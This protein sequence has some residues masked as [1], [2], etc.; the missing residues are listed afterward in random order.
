MTYPP[1]HDVFSE[2][3]PLL[4]SGKQA[5]ALRQLCCIGKLITEYQMSKPLHADRHAPC[6]VYLPYDIL[7]F[8]LEHASLE[9]Y[10]DFGYSFFGHTFHELPK[11]YDQRMIVIAPMTIHSDDNILENVTDTKLVYI[12]HMKGA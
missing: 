7:Y 11:K 12:S 5:L 10:S 2:R 8:I 3:I 4:P 1:P 9:Y 6:S